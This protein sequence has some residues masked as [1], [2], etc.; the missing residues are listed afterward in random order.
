MLNFNSIGRLQ[1]PLHG[2][3]CL[4]QKPTSEQTDAMPTS[5]GSVI[6]ANYMADEDAAVVQKL[7]AQGAVILGKTNL[8]EFCNYVSIE[9]NSGY[10]FAW[11]ANPFHFWTRSCGWRLQLGIRGGSRG[12]LLQLLHRDRNRRVCG[13]SRRSQWCICL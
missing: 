3:P 1:G 2:I 13:L 6:L 9:T 7:R 4:D 10:S 11:R 8:S 5:C 12:Q